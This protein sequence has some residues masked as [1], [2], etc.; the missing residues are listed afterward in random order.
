[1]EFTINSICSV[2]VLPAIIFIK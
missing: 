2:R 1:M